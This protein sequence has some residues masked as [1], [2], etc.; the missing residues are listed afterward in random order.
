M[1]VV[2]TATATAAAVGGRG[3]DGVVVRVGL[4]LRL[5]LGYR[6]VV[7][8]GL[9]LGLRLRW[10][11]LL[12]VEVLDDVLL[13][14]PEQGRRRTLWRCQHVG[15]GAGDNAEGGALGHRHDLGWLLAG[16]RRVGG[17]AV[18]LRDAVG[19]M[20]VGGQG[21]AE[22]AGAVQGTHRLALV[23]AVDVL[24]LDRHLKICCAFM[25]EQ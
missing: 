16:A 15:L 2:S 8:V 25:A 17:G 24:A 13:D 9:G 21:H 6:A 11:G 19:A 12:V 20:E 22:G 10:H 5:R 3:R 1:S 7:W 23:V 14:R 18:E 4:R